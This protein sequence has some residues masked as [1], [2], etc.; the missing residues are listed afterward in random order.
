M[1]IL[2][3]RPISSLKKLAR[4][5]EQQIYEQHSLKQRIKDLIVNLRLLSLSSHERKFV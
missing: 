4:H 1:R 3:A 2:G 5:L